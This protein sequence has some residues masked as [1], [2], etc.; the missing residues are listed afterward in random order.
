VDD[1]QFSLCAGERF[2]GFASGVGSAGLGDF[3]REVY[4]WAGEFQ[5]D[6]DFALWVELGRGGHGHGR[7]DGAVLLPGVFRILSVE[8]GRGDAVLHDYGGWVFELKIRQVENGF[9]AEEDHV[10]LGR[11]GFEVG[12]FFYVHSLWS[13]GGPRVASSLIQAARKE[14]RRQGFKTIQFYVNPE[15]PAL[16]KFAINGRAKVRQIWMETKA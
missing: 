10:V 4:L 13:G 8:R 14:A 9:V 1:L 2:G 15:A 11:I 7:L 5:R 3:G 6:L 12:V 16:M